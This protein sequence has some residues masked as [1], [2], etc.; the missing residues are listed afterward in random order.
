MSYFL[1]LD[2]QRDPH[3][4]IVKFPAQ[5]DCYEKVWVK[6][7]EEFCSTINSRGLPSVVSFDHDLGIQAMNEGTNKRYNSFDYNNLNGEKTGLDAAR[8]T[9]KYCMEKKVKLPVTFCHS[10]NPIGKKN[11]LDLLNKYKEKL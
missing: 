9:I 2:D 8:F 7:Y 10:M 11:I 1:F 6:S 4:G 3:K 5:Y